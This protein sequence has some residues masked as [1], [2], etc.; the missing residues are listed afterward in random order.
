MHEHLTAVITGEEA[1][2]FVGVIPLGLASGHEREPLREE[3]QSG[4]A[5]AFAPPHQAIGCRPVWAMAKP[6]ARIA[7]AAWP[8]R[9]SVEPPLL[10]P[11]LLELPPGRLLG[12]PDQVDG[13]QQGQKPAQVAAEYPGLPEVGP[14]AVLGTAEGD[15]S[16]HP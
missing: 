8:D 10:L 9:P 3:G 4:Q 13:A 14:S 7:P 12:P 15:V 16:G 1:E 2:A 11:R 5:P 6:P